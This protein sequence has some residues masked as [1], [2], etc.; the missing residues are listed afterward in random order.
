MSL[1][2]LQIQASPRG[3]DSVSR[4]ITQELLGA[5]ARS[6]GPL[7]IVERDL[8]LVP[9]SLVDGAWIEAS[10]TEPM[11]RTT[12]QRAALAE[13]D[14]LVREL[15]A[16]QVLVIGTPVYNFGLPAVVKAWIDQVARARLTFRY[17]PE[18]PIGLLGDK[19]ALVVMSSG[20][21]QLGG[22]GDYASTHLRHV[23]GFLGIEDVEVVAADRLALDPEASVRGARGRIAE[24]FAAPGQPRAAA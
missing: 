15:L 20:G 3:T 1:N 24:L 5:L 19:R 2:V 18:G 9:P 22:P 10:A 4:Q 8:A 17:T 23:L 12:A 21:T 7:Q 13:S 16:A 6:E 14:E 11:L